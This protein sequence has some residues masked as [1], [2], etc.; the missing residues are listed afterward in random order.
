MKILDLLH[1]FL[2]PVNAVALSVQLGRYDVS[3]IDMTLDVC[4]KPNAVKIC[5]RFL[6]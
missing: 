6:Q 1:L 4:N 2:V 3:L 5:T